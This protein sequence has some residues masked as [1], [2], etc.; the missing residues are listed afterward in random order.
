MPSHEDYKELLIPHALD[1]LERAEARSLE[2]HLETCAECRTELDSWR[3][4]TAK[5]AFA[6]E[7]AE[8][9]ALLRTRI[10]DNA[11]ALGQPKA[12]TQTKV[13]REA[14][15]TVTN[16]ADRESSNIIQ[17]PQRRAWSSSQIFGAIAAS[18]L[19]AALAISSIV[20]WQRNKAMEAETA[21]LSRQLKEQEQEIVKAK[22][23]K[24]MLTAPGSN[25]AMLG[26]TE[27]AKDAR[28]RIAYDRQTG[29]AMLIADGLPPAP[30]GKAYQLWFIVEGKPPMPGGV[31]N[32]DA[33]GHAEM[34]DQMPSEGRHAGVF[35]VTLERAGG[36]P[37]PEGKAYLQGKAS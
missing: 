37:A 19:I 20:L 5:L 30:A 23:D 3:A 15:E 31:F 4:T 7:V 16:Y 29:R 10:L 33:N 8:P 17:M 21:R 22:E 28:A 26:G 24:S 13:K 27:M 14:A 36:V 6:A 35:A 1:A 25:M 9:S 18:L 12:N 32:T 34:R 11:V 2:E